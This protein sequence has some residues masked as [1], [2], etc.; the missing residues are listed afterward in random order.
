[1]HTR[2]ELF[3]RFLRRRLNRTA[4]EEGKAG[5]EQNQKGIKQQESST[6]EYD[7]FESEEQRRE[8]LER[9]KKNREERA[10][11]LDLVLNRSRLN[12]RMQV[13]NF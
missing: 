7:E 10:K 6:N 2:A 9:L 5:V 12:T 8:Y 1:M 3:W 11:K 13:G 4:G